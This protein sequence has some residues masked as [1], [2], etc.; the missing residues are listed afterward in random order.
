MKKIAVIGNGPTGQIL[1]LLLK[2]FCKC[3]RVVD[4]TDEKNCVPF[5]ANDIERGILKQFCDV[6]GISLQTCECGMRKIHIVP[7]DGKP[8]CCDSS[9]DSFRRGL[10]ERFPEQ[11]EAIGRLF[12]DIEDVGEEWATLI[13]NHFDASRGS[14]KKSAAYANMTLARYL[15]RAGISGPDVKEI[16]FTVLPVGD[17]T[18]SVFAGYFYTQFFDIHILCQDL[19]KEIAGK[20]AGLETVVTAGHLENIVIEKETE[21]QAEEGILKNMDGVIDLRC[22][23]LTGRPA[24]NTRKRIWAGTFSTCQL[25]ESR[26]Y[27]L[28]MCDGGFLRLWKNLYLPW[29]KEDQWQFEALMEES[30]RMDDKK[31]SDLVKRQ[32]RDCLGADIHVKSVC[33]PDYFAAHYDTPYGYMWAFNPGQSRMDP[34]DLYKKQK[35]PCI[36]MGYW[37]FAWFSAAFCLYHILLTQTE[38]GEQY[39]L[40]ER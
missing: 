40:K 37:G 1:A 30:S 25:D 27:H 29:R 14:M 36:R 33:G 4:R 39:I 32:V 31:V 24:E 17:V 20:A 15:E 3:V 26:I 5:Y 6:A 8:F 28:A 11:K 9:M 21:G 34:S 23:R 22:S 2:D 38:W 13:R 19:W 18:F 7:G 16:L 35:M 10:E 12:A